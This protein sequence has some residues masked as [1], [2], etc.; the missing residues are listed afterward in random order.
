MVVVG[1]E[2][3]CQGLGA[4][5]VGCVDAGVG[6]LVGEGAVESFNFTVLLGLVGTDIEVVNVTEGFANKRF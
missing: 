4:F 6:P 1:V 3:L 5:G 2:P